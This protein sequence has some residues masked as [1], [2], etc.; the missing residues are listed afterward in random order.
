[1]KA[2]RQKL[3]LVGYSH[4]AFI[5]FLM[6]KDAR[7]FNMR[8]ES[9]CLVDPTPISRRS[10]P[11][12]TY[13]QLRAVMYD[14][15]FQN[16]VESHTGLS[17]AVLCGSITSVSALEMEVTSAF[18]MLHTESSRVVDYFLFVSTQESVEF[19]QSN[20]HRTNRI[21]SLFNFGKYAGS[22]LFLKTAGAGQHYRA[23]QY[24]KWNH[25]VYGWNS[26]LRYVPAKLGS[27]EGGHYEA[28]LNVN[29]QRIGSALSRDGAGDHAH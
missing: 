22:I 17:Y 29:L 5:A 25:P 21:L 23:L 10:F 9:F 13:L 15:F 3:T 27:L 1:M 8:I 20:V 28:F 2:F 14:E 4:G 11:Q 24:H 12:C 16:F 7:E 26:L 18:P 19:I 6:V